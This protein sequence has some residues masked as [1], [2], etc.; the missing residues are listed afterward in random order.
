MW[1]RS[2]R[3]VRNFAGRSEVHRSEVILGDGKNSEEDNG[4]KCESPPE[5]SLAR[6]EGSGS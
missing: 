4:D 5:G 6:K 1:M 2:F 3:K